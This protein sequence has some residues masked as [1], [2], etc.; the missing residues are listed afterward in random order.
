MA[1][2]KISEL[3]P[4]ANLSSG[5]F[6]VIVDDTDTTTKKIAARNLVNVNQSNVF[7]RINTGELRLPTSGD[8]NLSGQSGSVTRFG[9]LPDPFIMLS[10][11]PEDSAFIGENDKIIMTK[12][13]PGLSVTG[14]FAGLQTYG[15]GINNTALGRSNRPGT[16]DNLFDSDSS[17]LGKDDLLT[18]FNS[19]DSFVDVF[20]T[21]GRGAEFGNGTDVVV[22][23]RVTGIDMIYQKVSEGSELNGVLEISGTVE[24]DFTRTVTY[25]VDAEPSD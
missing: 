2:K 13:S 1:D 3:D 15:T 17:F 25:V 14:P 10:V 21:L 6:F 5:D 9:A 7:D 18:N 24:V 16:A 22:T 8:L 11:K 19:G 23:C 4:L 12:F 20:A